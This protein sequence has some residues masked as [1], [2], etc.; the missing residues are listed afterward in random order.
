MPELCCAFTFLCVTI[1]CHLFSEPPQELSEVCLLANGPSQASVQLNTMITIL[2]VNVSILITLI[3]SSGLH[4]I[5]GWIYHLPHTHSK[6][7]F[8]NKTFSLATFST[9]FA[10]ICHCKQNILML[11]FPLLKIRKCTIKAVPPNIKLLRMKLNFKS[12]KHQNH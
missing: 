12:F 7:I 11:L 10:L 3:H 5:C 4:S 8:K 9:L 2:L 1:K 6:L